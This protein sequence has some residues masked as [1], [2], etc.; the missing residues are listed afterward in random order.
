MTPLEELMRALAAIPG[1]REA[2]EKAAVAGVR[3]ALRRVAQNAQDAA[4]G[5]VDPPES[6]LF[7]IRGGQR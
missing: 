6:L 5:M 3:F 2:L 1:D 7:L 4:D